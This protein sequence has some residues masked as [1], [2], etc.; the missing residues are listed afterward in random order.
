MGGELSVIHGGGKIFNFLGLFKINSKVGE[1]LAVMEEVFE[2]C[3]VGKPKNTH[4]NFKNPPI[5][6]K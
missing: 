6:S 5:T 1:I 2:T 3:D 4:N